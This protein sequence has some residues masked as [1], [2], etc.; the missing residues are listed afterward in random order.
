[1]GSPGYTPVSVPQP[2]PILAYIALGANLGDRARNI[3]AALHLLESLP[4]IRVTKVS[5]LLE[6][7][8]VG[9]PADSPPFLNAVAQIETT[10]EPRQL[11]Q[12]LLDIEH[13]LGRE[14]NL[15]WE[16]RQIDLDLLLFGEV[17]ISQPHLVIPHPRM[18]ER[19]FVL[20]P[21]A[22]IAPKAWHPVLKRT[23]ADLLRDLP[24]AT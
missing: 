22:E 8:A 1:M 9:G 10:L 19:R 20:E 6:N 24:G 11:L 15:K 12:R 3:Q 18:H 16:P 2:A 14:R 17:V 4:G 21:L 13:E 5:S 23:I 7:P